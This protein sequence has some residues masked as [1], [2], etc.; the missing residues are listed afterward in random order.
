MFLHLEGRHFVPIKNIIAILNIETIAKTKDGKEILSLIKK[1]EKIRDVSRGRAKSWVIC[2]DLIYCS[3]ISSLTLK[4]R[5]KNL[6]TE[7][8]K[9]EHQIKPRKILKIPKPR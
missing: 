6:E 7:V 4:K 5:V 8:K 9:N 1:P 2:D 3:S